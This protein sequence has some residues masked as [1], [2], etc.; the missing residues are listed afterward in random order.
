MTAT[1][2]LAIALGYLLGAIPF[3][4]LLVKRRLGEDV[5]GG[6]DRDLRRPGDVGELRLPARLHLRVVVA[7][8]LYRYNPLLTRVAFRS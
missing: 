8:D 4:Y 7:H 3:G 6:S 5:R 2:A 1:D